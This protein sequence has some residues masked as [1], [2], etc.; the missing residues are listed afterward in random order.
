VIAPDG[1]V[2]VAGIRR[3]EP[4]HAGQAC[5]HYC[6]VRLLERDRPLE[7][8]LDRARRATEGVGSLVLVTGEAGIGKTVL[9][10]RFAERIRPEHDPLWGMCDSLSTPRPLGPLRDVA[11]QLAPAVAALL[12]EGAPPYEVFAA[13]QDALRV[14]PRVLIVEDLHWAD[15]AT[16][17]LVRFLARRLA[18]LPT[19]LVLSYRDTIA[20]DHPLR[21]VLGDLVS[22]PDA[23]RVRLAPLSPAAVGELLAARDGV[24]VADVHRRTAGNPFFVSQIAAQPDSPLPES[25]RDAVVPGWRRCPGRPGSGWSCS[26]AP[27]RE[28]AGRCCPRSRCPPRP[29]AR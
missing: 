7:A 18:G 23:Q 14:G 27:P 11:A 13:V 26:P 16:L 2:T 5:L 8:L 21:P 20:S 22:I 24:D 3:E 17:D 12:R 19:L 10:R 6:F 9:L 25:V 28:S 4:V 15:E 1:C 29:S